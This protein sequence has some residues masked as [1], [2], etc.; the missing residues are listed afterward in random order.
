MADKLNLNPGDQQYQ[1]RINRPGS[2][3]DIERQVANDYSHDY[4]APTNYAA[5]EQGSKS[6]LASM[7]KSAGEQQQSA[8]TNSQ[9][10][11]TQERSASFE[12][13]GF[14]GG[15]KAAGT[16]QLAKFSKF[17]KMAGIGILGITA[18]GGAIALLFQAVMLLQPIQNSSILQFVGG[19]DSTNAEGAVRNMTNTQSIATGAS[20]KMT[21]DSILKRYANAQS[22]KLVERLGKKGVT[23]SSNG[24]EID[25]SGKTQGEI[26]NM[27][28]NLGIS[29]ATQA[30]D[31]KIKIPK[32]ISY[33]DARKV[34]KAFDDPGNWNVNSWLQ[35]RYTLKRYKYTS[36]LHPLQKA[37][38][39]VSD[40]AEFIKNIITSHIKADSSV[41]SKIDSIANSQRPKDNNDSVNS[42]RIINA[43]KEKA[44]ATYARVGKL[45]SSLGSAKAAINKAFSNIG[46][47]NPIGPAAIVVGLVCLLNSVQQMAGPYKWTSVVVP[48]MTMGSLL[49]G[50][51]S[52]VKSGDDITMEQLGN[53]TKMAYGSN[54]EQLDT[55]GSS[56]NPKEYTFSSFNQSDVIC[57]FLDA[58]SCGDDSK[59]NVP[60]SLLAVSS[61][62][63]WFGNDTI[64]K[65]L[66]FVLGNPVTSV[67][68][69]IFST[70]SDILNSLILWD[71]VNQA[72]QSLILPLLMEALTHV[73]F[74]SWLLEQG[75]NWIFG[76]AINSDTASPAMWGSIAAFG[77]VFMSISQARTKGGVK[78][79]DS[80]ARELKL[81]NQRY[82]AWEHQQ[83]PLIARL[84]DPADYSSGINVIARSIKADNSSSSLG[85][86]VANI[87]RLFTSAPSMLATASGQ[88]LGGSAY[89]A[90]NYNYGVS[91]WGWNLNEMNVITA[92]QGD[93][94]IAANTNYVLDRLYEEDTDPKKYG[95]EL[96]DYAK[97][98]FSATISPGD[99]KVT[100][101]DNDT[102]EAWNFLDD[103]GDCSANPGSKRFKLRLYINDYFSTVGSMCYEG[104][105]DSS[106]AKAACNEM[107]VTGNGG[108]SNSGGV[109]SGA[110]SSSQTANE[111]QQEFASTGGKY[112]GYV[113]SYNGCT[114]VSAWYIGTHTTL[115][116][117]NGNGGD[118]AANLVA[119][120][121]GAGLSVSNTPKAPAIFSTRDSQF[122]AAM[123]GG[124]KCGHTGLVT[125]VAEDGTIT[126]LE[127]N[128]SQGAPNY[129]KISVWP[130]SKYDG[131]MTFVY[132]GDHLK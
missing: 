96:H 103:G 35:S 27:L 71:I 108:G 104:D 62:N 29:K 119:A 98:C 59:R 52:Q 12:T 18:G 1:D 118:V 6:S 100:I 56:K 7:E 90:T 66:D 131:K 23:V 55:D 33:T 111:L 115:T 101:A 75:A 65:V 19:L 49:V 16:K 78:L 44:S 10:L 82:L 110:S 132:V 83:K 99:Y 89:A 40:L 57:H 30:A 58:N 126:V 79:S 14:D 70:L 46:I 116:Y 87:F 36:W 95:T 47:F 105:A 50:V 117:G 43:L 9:D 125:D 5:G 114:T 13:K 122:A 2:I 11:G 84:F 15:V 92:G 8:G 63:H 32:N 130:K 60:D 34:I 25:V 94:D 38:N 120:N 123:C 61:P 24:F 74:F 113:V 39:K 31:G 85:T 51:G 112:N 41:A 128:S 80:Q 20:D 42:N 68:C 3:G 28:D 107:G 17:K 124:Q 97:R 77:V 54:I 73:E 106:D 72:V 91:D 21:R 22:D 86:Q 109:D 45:R 64:N 121:P 48:A 4:S 53:V 127:T 93:Y 76:T 67:V 129:S 88:L 102:G 26:A 81:E 69:F 37:K